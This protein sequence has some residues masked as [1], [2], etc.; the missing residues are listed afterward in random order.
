ML[1]KRDVLIYFW[2]MYTVFVSLNIWYGTGTTSNSW[3]IPSFNKEC[4]TDWLLISS[5]LSF[6]EWM[7]YVIEKVQR[8]VG[9]KI[10]LCQHDLFHRQATVDWKHNLCVLGASTGLL[11]IIFSKLSIFEA[12]SIQHMYNIFLAP[13]KI[14]TLFLFSVKKTTFYDKSSFF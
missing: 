14:C 6:L 1:I 5:S 4:N 10:I 7:C 11:H 3:W 2:K 9:S 8:K 12:Y 13:R